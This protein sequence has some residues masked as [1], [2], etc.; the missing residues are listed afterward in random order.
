MTQGSILTLTSNPTRT[1]PVKRGK[2]LLENILGTPPP[3]APGGV[4]PL[5]D[6]RI[7]MEKL[8][9]RQQFEEH[10]A[11]ASCAGCHAFL[12]P[13]GFAFENYDAVGRWRD[14]DKGNPVDAAGS[15]V[16]GQKF[17]NFADLRTLLT[18]ELSG[19]FERNLAENL[20]TYALGRGLEHHDKPAVR[21]VV[22]RTQAA[23]HRFQDMIIA[24]CESVP[25]QRMR[26]SE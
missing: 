15:L 13:M 11:N 1:S 26:V 22:K 12:D 20:L 8:T 19:D 7:D 5:D 4:P 18:N 10:R 9:L 2:F 25:F 14:T 17:N 21:E 24:V 16:R 23:E 3:P 6:K